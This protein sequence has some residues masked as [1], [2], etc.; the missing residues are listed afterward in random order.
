MRAGLPRKLS[1]RR[2]PSVEAA[3]EEVCSV[4]EKGAAAAWIRNTV[5]DAIEACAELE[6][7]DL[8]PLLLHARFA[9]GDRL[10]KE[11]QIQEMLGRDSKP[12]QRRGF[13]VVG[14]QILEASLD[15]DVDSMVT[16]LAPVDLIIQRAGRLWR[17]PGREGRFSSAPE[18]LVLSPDYERVENA[19]WYASIS[20]RAAG[21]YRDPGI[22]WNTAKALFEAGCIDTPGNIRDLIEKVYGDARPEIPPVFQRKSAEADGRAAGHRSLAKGNLLVLE[23]GYWG[24]NTSWQDD[25]KYPT[26]LE[27]EP[28]V[29]FRLGKVANGEIVPWFEDENDNIKLSWA[30]S[31]VSIAKRRASGV[32]T[33][34]GEGAKLVKAAKAD[35]GKWEQDIPL[36]LLTPDGTS[37]RG[38]VTCDEG[39]RDMLYDTR[40]GLRLAGNELSQCDGLAVAGLRA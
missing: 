38:K 16:D 4:A 36:L 1:V 39:E 9:M 32:P 30:L 29:L 15:Y 7:R 8:K 6:Q 25:H 17:H 27:E 23:K 28:S 5:D 13:V 3:V 22:V 24:N 21:V 11:K 12:E 20:K 40:L 37:W 26:R 34:S 33:P 19:D 35:W 31:E 14:T 18:L 2:L 10:A